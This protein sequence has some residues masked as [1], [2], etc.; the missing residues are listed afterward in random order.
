MHIG[1]TFSRP[2]ASEV[3]RS[4]FPAPS[5]ALCAMV[6]TG[7]GEPPTPEVRE[8]TPQR[9]S[10]MEVPRRPVNRLGMAGT[11]GRVPRTVRR[12]REA[13]AAK[14]DA[15]SPSS[16]FGLHLRRTRGWSVVTGAPWRS[17]AWSRSSSVGFMSAAAT[18]VVLRGRRVR[19]AAHDGCKKCGRTDSPGPEPS[20]RARAT[21]GP[22]CGPRSAPPCPPCTAPGALSRSPPPRRARAGGAA[23]G[24]PRT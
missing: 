15:A 1:C 2:V 4:L 23:D 22:A 19:L 21:S 16:P 17:P 7:F 8:T 12:R 14:G 5:E 11:M 9:T 18:A 6:H 20:P 13:R 3:A 24:L 10:H